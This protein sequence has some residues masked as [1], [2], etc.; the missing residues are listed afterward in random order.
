M[1]PAIVIV[2]VI[3]T[4][5]AIVVGLVAYSYT[6]IQFSL[7]S[8]SYQGLDVSL[9]GGSIVKTI[10]NGIIGNW[11][12]AVLD[13]I[14]GV[15]LGLGFALSNHGF[16]PVYIPDVSYD[17][18]VNDVKVGQGQSHI[19]KTI[20]PG[21]TKSIEDIQDIQFSSLKPAAA[22]VID[23]GGLINFKVSGTAYFSFL[24][25]SVPVPFETTKQVNIVD[26]LKSKLLGSRS[27]SSEYSN[28]SYQSPPAT[29]TGIS[30]QA[31]AYTA[32]Q[33]Q[34]VTFTG[35]LTDSNGN[36]ISN[37]LVYV[38]RD[39]SF[40]PDSVLGSSYT[41]SNGYFDINWIVTKPITGN[42]ADIYATFDGSSGYSSVRSSDISIQVMTYQPQSISIPSQSVS[43][44]TDKTSYNRDTTIIISGTVNPTIPNQL[45]TLQ[46]WYRGDQV[47]ER[48]ATP[49]LDGTFSMHVSFTSILLSD[50]LY[51][52][53]AKYG[54]AQ[55]QTTFI[56][57]SA[58][59]PII[60]P[61]QT[62]PTTQTASFPIAN[63]Q[64]QVGP[65]TYTTIPFNMQCSGTVTGSFSASATLGDN[66]IV[67]I[68]DSSGYS[69][70]QAGNSASTY[71]NS[72][73]VS[74]GTFN[75][76][77]SSGQYYLVLS[78]TYSSF[79]TKTVN[80]SASYTCS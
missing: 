40:A 71:Y 15:K 4:I 45:V 56:F 34:T 57:G 42:T 14:T 52:V 80:I 51:T 49:N 10:L 78:N 27:Q 28:N 1:K 61:I 60:P 65:G 13:L 35:R 69:Q 48:V 64:Y 46:I 43:V 68:M 24:G 5:I 7:E 19:D 74:S 2:A 23:S 16:F 31:S 53:I 79:S 47:S 59:Q 58:S 54:D 36:G 8:I 76:G 11:L 6:Q 67:Y 18:L 26:E 38:K 21:E 17:L 62:S 20:N 30:L 50:G 22:S 66:I 44:Y 72:D 73:K 29:G 63:S 75:V 70:F 12:G 32:T 77:L 9:T 3:I 55:S 39:I 41:D 37:Q 33:G 25:L